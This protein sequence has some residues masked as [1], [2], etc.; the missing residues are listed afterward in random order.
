MSQFPIKSKENG[1]RWGT[2]LTANEPA[3]LV[4]TNVRWHLATGAAAV[5][6]FLDDPD[7]PAAEV[8][9]AI[10]GCTMQCC[11]DAYWRARRPNK[12]RPP[13]QMRRQTINANR[14]QNRCDLDWLFHID[15]DEFIWQDGDLSA[16]LSAHADPLTELNLPVLERIFPAGAQSTLFDGAYRASSDLSEDDAEAAFAPFARFMKRGQ[17]SHG[18]GKSGVQVGAGLRLG[19]HNAT[20]TGSEGRQRRAAKRVST[21]A[22]LLHFDGMTPLH[23]VMKVL[24]YRQTPPEVQATILQ[25]H[26]AEQIAWMLEKSQN[27]QEA[28][29]AHHALFAMTDARHAQLNRF[30]LLRDISFD[31][32]RVL[33]PACPDLSVAAFDAEL[34][35]RNPELADVINA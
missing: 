7:D 16:E 15:A 9:S 5:Y 6:V 29:A 31:P 2:V 25:P 19:V 22:R 30:D 8:L 12:G 11:D 3:A 26:R 13:S 34:M 10:D 21:T 28:M 1:L 33:G 23:W 35:R 27:R 24:R 14:A 4:E 17:Y 18:A 32:A 20:R